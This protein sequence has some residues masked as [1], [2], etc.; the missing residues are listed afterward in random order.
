MGYKQAL[1]THGPLMVD[2]LTGALMVDTGYALAASY[3]IPVGADATLAAILAGLAGSP[4]LPATTLRIAI[5]PEDS[6]KVIRYAHGETAS[7]STPAWPIAGESVPVTKTVADAI[8]LFA[9]A[10]TYATLQVFV[11]RS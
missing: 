1:T 9:A 10:A 7:G 11:P 6:A 3:R 4:T 5:I 2:E 8:H